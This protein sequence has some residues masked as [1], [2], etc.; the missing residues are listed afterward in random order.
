MDQSIVEVDGEEAKLVMAQFLGQSMGF[1]KEIDRNI[2]NRTN[3]LQGLTMD[4]MDIIN[5]L[6]GGGQ[7]TRQLPPQ[8]GQFVPPS[9]TIPDII[10][11]Q[12]LTEAVAVGQQTVSAP[13]QQVDK[14][15]LEFTF[16]YNVAEDIANKLSSLD[17]RVRN[18]EINI[19]NIL[20]LLE[21]K[22]KKKVDRSTSS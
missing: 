10:V 2:T 16:D 3:T 8:P 18:I 7:P 20:T 11:T 14:D 21:S 19:E 13:Q 6:P 17:K 15:Q 1:L 9:V 4:P 12:P 22:Y 5:K